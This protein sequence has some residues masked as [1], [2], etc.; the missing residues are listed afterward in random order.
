MNKDKQRIAIAEACGWI[1]QGTPEMKL[2]AFGCWTRPNGNSW[3]LEQP[4]DYLSDLNAMHEA[5]KVLTDEKWPVYRD[6]LRTV[7]LGP[8][9]SVSQWCKADLHATAEEKA[10]AFLRTLS[11]WEDEGRD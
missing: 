1:Y 3:Q 8:V 11:L 7:I 10:A 9:R 5:E 4:P 2:V 6:E